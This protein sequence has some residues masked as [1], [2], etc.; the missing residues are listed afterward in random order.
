MSDL[1]KQLKALREAYAS[2]TIS[3]MTPEEMASEIAHHEA[4][5]KVKEAKL[6]RL[7]KKA[8]P[9]APA[10]REA[11]ALL[12]TEIPKKSSKPALKKEA[13]APKKEPKKVKVVES[14]SEMSD[15]DED[16]DQETIKS[17]IQKK[18]RLSSE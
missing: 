5:A 4:A 14:D 17:R 3:K 15:T 12:V 18:G 9:M 7:A 11:P 1:K 2:K 16:T 10:K 6:K 8:A 13:A